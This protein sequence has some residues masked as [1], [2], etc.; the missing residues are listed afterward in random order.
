MQVFLAGDFNNWDTQSLPMKRGKDG[1]WKAK[2][3][4]PS[5]R[6]SIKTSC[7]PSISRKARRAAPATGCSS[8]PHTYAKAL[9]PTSFPAKRKKTRLHAS[10]HFNLRDRGE[11]RFCSPFTQTHWKQ[12][13][14]IFVRALKKYFSLSDYTDLKKWFHRFLFIFQCIC[15][16]C[17]RFIIGVIR[18]FSAFSEISIPTQYQL[19]LLWPS[20]DEGNSVF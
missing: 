18:D 19:T 16:P 17:N 13:H 11:L 4:L 9:F 6:R 2:I 8:F 20:G 10:K 1:V 15:N 14:R 5:G 12:G 7:A 3:K